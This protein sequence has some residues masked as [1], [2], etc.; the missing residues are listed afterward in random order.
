MNGWGRGTGDALASVGREA[1]WKGGCSQDWLPR[2]PAFRRGE[3]AP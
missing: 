3:A 1:A 2:G